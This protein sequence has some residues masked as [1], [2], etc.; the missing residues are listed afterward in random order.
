MQAIEVHYYIWH[1]FME[2]LMSL[3]IGLCDRFSKDGLA[4]LQTTI[5]RVC[6]DNVIN[7]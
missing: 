7:W 5:L 2:S 6:L 4:I 1:R 3:S